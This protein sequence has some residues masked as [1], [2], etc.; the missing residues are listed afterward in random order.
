MK[1]NC[2]ARTPEFPRSWN[3]YAY[4]GN[5]PLAHSDPSGFFDPSQA[6]LQGR[7]DSGGFGELGFDWN[8]FDFMFQAATPTA[9]AAWFKPFEN[10]EDPN[11]GAL[12]LAPIYG[13]ADLLDA[14]GLIIWSPQYRVLATLGGRPGQY[15]RF[16]VYTQTAYGLDTAKGAFVA[17]PAHNL[18]HDCV[19]IAA[20]SGATAVVPVGDIGPWNGRGTRANPLG[21]D[22]PYWF[23]GGVPETTSGIDLRGIL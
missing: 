18:K 22:D 8:E 9:V 14:L 16:H 20:P 21:Y 13:N 19:Q 5:Q 12:E 23:T 2:D 3:Q 7:L 4:V 10:T 15:G 1:V 6:Y 17:L 11:F